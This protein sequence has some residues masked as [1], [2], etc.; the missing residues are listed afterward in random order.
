MRQNGGYPNPGPVKRALRDP[1]EDWWDKQERRNYGEAVHEDNDILGMFSTEPYSHFTPGFGAVLLG[2]FVA[3][4]F[5]LCGVV[6][7]LRPDKPSV[8]K[9]YPGGLE[10][11]LG[12][13]GAVRVSV[14][15]LFLS[16]A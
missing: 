16:R 14:P 13:A 9:T 10:A 5:A 4:V 6:S 2:T 3:S 11:E 15:L 8:P 1:Y 7:V 12:G